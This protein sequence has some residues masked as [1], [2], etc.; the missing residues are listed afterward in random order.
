MGFW[1][2]TLLVVVVLHFVVGFGYLVI[3]LSPRKDKSQKEK[4]EDSYKENEQN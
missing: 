4:I 2:V 3:K 1:T